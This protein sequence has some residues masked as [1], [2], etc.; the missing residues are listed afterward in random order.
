M[1]P[2]LENHRFV[3]DVHLGELAR[4]APQERRI[5]LSNDRALLMRR[6]VRYG[7]MVRAEDPRQ[8]VLQPVQNEEVQS[9]LPPFPRRCY[10][11]FS[12]CHQCRRI[13]WEGVHSE[14][15]RSLLS[16]FGVNPARDGRHL[17]PPSSPHGAQLY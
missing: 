17:E 9:E 5:L 11:R 1:P 6:G 8:Q 15:L 3:L 16:A 14:G 10:R 7:A 2:P 13:S 12:C 4:L